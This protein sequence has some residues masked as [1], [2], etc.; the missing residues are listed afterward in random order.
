M[1]VKV[2][3]TKV[4]QQKTEA[5]VRIQW[6]SRTL[7]ARALCLPKSGETPLRSG[8]I[9]G[10]GGLASQPPRNPAAGS[11]T[12]FP[13]CP[14]R[15]LLSLLLARSW[16]RPLSPA[17]SGDALLGDWRKAVLGSGSGGPC[18]CTSISREEGEAATSTS[19]SCY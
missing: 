8:H 6:G 15:P 13:S 17:S 10:A 12:S 18:F 3:W 11:L 1:E 2:S 4:V 14:P 19:W 16:K 5:Q 9:A 7:R